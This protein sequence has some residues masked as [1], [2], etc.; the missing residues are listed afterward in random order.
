MGP[1][2]IGTPPVRYSSSSVI[3]I[4]SSIFSDH[5]GQLSFERHKFEN[6]ESFERV[7]NM[8]LEMVIEETGRAGTTRT[9]VAAEAAS[10]L[11]DPVKVAGVRF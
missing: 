9:V 7:E 3:C 4:T 2:G 6:F 1:S 5:L 10:T 8:P 11:A